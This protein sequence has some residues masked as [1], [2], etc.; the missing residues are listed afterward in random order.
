MNTIYF[1]LFICPAS[2]K[3]INEASDEGVYACDGWW[4]NRDKETMKEAERMYIQHKGVNWC[5]SKISMLSLQNKV[6]ASR[7]NLIFIK[8][9]IQSVSATPAGHVLT[10]YHPFSAQNEFLQ[11]VSKA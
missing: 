7:E 6:L 3:T 1:L 11:L 2:S 5:I 4:I 10:V 8:K 9:V